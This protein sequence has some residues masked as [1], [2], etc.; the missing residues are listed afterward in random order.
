MY[1]PDNVI[2]FHDV[3]KG[4]ICFL[5]MDFEEVPKVKSSIDVN[6]NLTFTAYSAEEIIPESSYSSKMKFPKAYLGYHVAM[7][8]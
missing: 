5:N 2:L 6:P 7:Y 1:K 8:N 3:S 4:C